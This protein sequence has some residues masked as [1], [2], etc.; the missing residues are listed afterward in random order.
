MRRFWCL[1]VAMY[2]NLLCS[3]RIL[4]AVRCQ[5]DDVVYTTS[6]NVEIRVYPGKKTQSPFD[7][8][9]RCKELGFLPPCSSSNRT[10]LNPS[11]SWT[12]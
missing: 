12:E 10:T 2:H 11:A 5:K 8:I 3:Y 7:F 1:L 6:N 4:R 9:V